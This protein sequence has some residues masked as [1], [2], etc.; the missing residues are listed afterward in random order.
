MTKRT[1]ALLI[2]GAV[3]AAAPATL[4]FAQQPPAAAREA[5]PSMT[6][7]QMV[8][9]RAERL[10]ATLQLRPDQ[11][12]A[13]RAYLDALRPVAAPPRPTPAQPGQMATTPQRLDAMRARIA[14]RQA[15]FNRMAAATLRFYGQLSPAQQKAF[16]AA[17]PGGGKFASRGHDD[18][19]HGDR[20]GPGHRP[21]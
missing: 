14:E 12:P 10:R 2:C 7:E 16:D 11:E 9:R 20:G 15:R 1:V 6:P 8:E 3:A 13:L 17:R 19:G 21:R 5:R 4:S 18:R